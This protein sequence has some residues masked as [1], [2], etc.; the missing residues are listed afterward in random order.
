MMQATSLLQENENST[1]A[2]AAKPGAMGIAKPGAGAVPSRRFGT[3]L[4][5]NTNVPVPSST[6]AGKGALAAA[7]APKPAAASTISAPPLSLDH[8]TAADV[9][10]AMDIDVADRYMILSLCNVFILANITLYILHRFN[11]MAVTDYVEDIYSNLRRKE[12]EL[13]PPANYMT[14]QDD[15]NDKMRTILVD[16]LIEVSSPILQFNFIFHACTNIYYDLT[17]FILQ[18]HL[19]FKLRHET[20]FLTVN[21]IDRFLTVQ[22]VA[23]QR[24]QVST[25]FTTSP[26]ILV[27]LILQLRR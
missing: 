11:E 15:I 20:L 9:A 4:S 5:V 26:L 7:Q 21:I 24:L 27:I 17:C 6:L 16:W 1:K 19:K 12:M 22:K 25:Q 14:N 8:V 10:G 3:A 23:R 2:M 13:A 18:V